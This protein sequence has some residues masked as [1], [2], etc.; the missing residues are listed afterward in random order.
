MLSQS[1]T[2][3][4]DILY[5][6]VCIFSV[7]ILLLFSEKYFSI[8]ETET[9]YKSLIRFHVLAESDSA[10]DQAIKLQVRDETLRL[11]KTPMSLAENAEA[12][13][14]Y[15]EENLDYIERSLNAFLNKTNT[16]YNATVSLV[17][18]PFPERCYG[19]LTLPAG[20]YKALRIS[21]GK[22]EGHNWWCILYPK[23][24]FVDETYT[25]S[26]SDKLL[27]NKYL[28]TD[29]EDNIMLNINTNEKTTVRFRSRIWER[30][31]SNER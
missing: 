10:K 8:S 1:K 6:I 15:I 9:V 20:N 18:E 26:L 31:T 16:P 27:F 24:C 14:I 11:L 7:L 21:L 30:L 17:E 19:S 5:Y 29:F 13:A 3:I 22:A 2:S 4:N 25:L 12:A 28:L 23:F